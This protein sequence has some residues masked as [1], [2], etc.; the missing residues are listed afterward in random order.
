[1]HFIT[2]LTFEGDAAAMPPQTPPAMFA[3]KAF[4]T[5]LFGTPA[6]PKFQEI[7]PHKRRTSKP[8]SQS[9]RE[10][11]GS[12]PT[13]NELPASKRDS[14]QL[15]TINDSK[16]PSSTV[17]AVQPIPFKITKK[18]NL[19]DPPT[20]TASELPTNLA[21]FT[22][23]K[24][25]ISPTKGILLTPGTAMTRKKAVTFHPS[26]PTATTPPTR[27]GHIRSGL[28]HEFPGK[29]PSP[30]TPKVSTA[31]HHQRS[32]SWSD[33][34][35]REPDGEEAGPVDKGK[36]V[37]KP[38]APNPTGHC[39]VGEGSRIGDFL[40]DSDGDDG[41]LGATAEADITVDLDAPRSNSGK[42]WKGRTEEI[43]DLAI[44]KV[45]KLRA[46][47]RL[48]IEY[49]E[50]K[51]GICANLSE[52]V[53]E[54]MEKNK[55]LK[56]ELK[57]LSGFTAGAPSTAT[58]YNNSSAYNS[59]AL[60]QAL[61]VI[62]EKDADLAAGE[63]ERARMEAVIESHKGRLQAFEEMLDQ[64][65][66]RIAELSMSM[67]GEVGQSPEDVVA[68]LRKKLRSAKLEAKEYG[69]V[70]LEA[71]NLRERV[72]SLEKSCLDV[73]TEKE[74]LQRELER[75][76]TYEGDAD[77]SLKLRSTAENR[78]KAQVEGLEKA[79]R[80][81]RAEAREKSLN[82][83]KERREAER[84]WRGDLA[85]ARGKTA[86]AEWEKEKLGKEIEELKEYAGRLEKELER[87]KIEY[88][89]LKKAA[90]S[91]PFA[92]GD[93]S[94]KELQT[95]QRTTA[96]ELR[97]ARE[98]T[99]YLKAQKGEA[100][101]LLKDARK[102]IEG[103]RCQ[104]NDITKIDI[105][106]VP[107]ISNQGNKEPE[108]ASDDSAV[109]RSFDRRNQLTS[110]PPPAP[111]PATPR[112]R[113]PTKSSALATMTS[114]LPI[115]SPETPKPAGGPF[116]PLGNA[117]QSPLL[118]PDLPPDTPVANNFYYQRKQ[119]ASPRASIVNLAPTPP[120]SGSTRKVAGVGNVVSRRVSVGGARATIGGGVTGT[121]GLGG[122]RRVSSI[123]MDP[124][125][126]AAAEKR[127]AERR[128][129]RNVANRASSGAL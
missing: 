69:L 24:R 111:A 22:P 88:D 78:L 8:N 102:E 124:A 36:N 119:K 41:P 103:L 37:E 45:G 10:E 30:W 118:L 59:Y 108:S 126:K 1:M 122:N 93:D 33:P 34:S 13:A 91:L 83:A 127:L 129:M 21:A 121:A 107:T 48:A 53:R 35:S 61:H 60:E 42:F 76:K 4:R 11:K 64:R 94:T 57:R 104:L 89:E 87:T 110:S 67:Y 15:G 97:K 58:G 7:P 79:R 49:A 32:A 123:A 9:A 5:T 68:D 109:D 116:D 73:T 114:K 112:D 90:S 98:E 101:E 95:K 25:P 16:P 40:D 66:S 23:V 27:I 56:G 75:A 85:D 113:S 6:P 63:Q 77:K 65:E 120:A 26:V 38:T 70:K 3:L 125:R 105:S 55:R 71:K 43:E 12:E 74:W 47:C 72:D 82:E 50:R 51:D 31:S 62:E 81:L 20:A 29:F 19:F 128:R 117:E 115:F 17:D 28:P 14:E 106:M 84:K 2:L 80:D 44:S 100:E 46:R 96:Q 92:V 18:T 54:L 99:F 52:Q 39:E 86:A